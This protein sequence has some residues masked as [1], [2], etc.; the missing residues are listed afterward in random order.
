LT[1][2]AR[3]LVQA[4][5]S[6]AEQ[7]RTKARVA[8]EKA[9]R[10][11]QMPLESTDHLEMLCRNISA[12]LSREARAANVAKARSASTKADKAAAAA[13]AKKAEEAAAAAAKK[14][15]EQAAAA[16]A[17]KKAEQEEAVR[18]RAAK[19]AAREVQMREQ[20]AAVARE[21]ANRWELERKATLAA[22][23]KQAAEARARAVEVETNARKEAAREVARH[24]Q[25]SAQARRGS[26]G[27]RLL[28]PSLA[29]L[30]L[31]AVGWARLPNAHPVSASLVE[32]VHA[33]PFDESLFNGQPQHERAQ[34][35]H[36]RSDA[37][38]PEEELT[39]DKILDDAVS[40]TVLTFHRTACS[41]SEQDRCTPL[42]FHRS[43]TARWARSM[44]SC[45][46]RSMHLLSSLDVQSR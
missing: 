46:A 8:K 4:L 12:N 20:Q 37:W 2:L 21:H 1:W 10:K 27:R 11:G 22:N 35:F 38:A 43:R 18:V 16:A 13:T 9:A 34:R 41:L 14:K 3:S 33:S 7:Q 15:A 6:A 19:K 40:C 17:K 26:K 32:A 24:Q 30:L 25:A 42:T 29:C 44:C 36:G 28:L 5:P 45:P 39:L 23:R 31:A